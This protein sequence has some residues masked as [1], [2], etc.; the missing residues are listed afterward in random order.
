M[1]LANGVGSMAFPYAY[2]N[3]SELMQTSLER[4]LVMLIAEYTVLMRRI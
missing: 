3:D 2:A 1:V 4:F